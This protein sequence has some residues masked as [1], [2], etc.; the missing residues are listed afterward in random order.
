MGLSFSTPNRWLSPEN[1]SDMTSTRLSVPEQL[2][3]VLVHTAFVQA[4]VGVSASTN[5]AT[6]LDTPKL[7]SWS[8]QEACATADQASRHKTP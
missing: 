3:S 2:A 5:D 7:A 6:E 8:A 1:S 4:S